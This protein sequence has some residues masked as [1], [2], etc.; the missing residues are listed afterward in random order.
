MNPE[1]DALNA[2]R[3]EVAALRRSLEILQARVDALEPEPKPEPVA[4]PPKPVESPRPAPPPHAFPSPVFSH[5]AVRKS[6]VKP[7]PIPVTPPEPSAIS[8]LIVRAKA[9]V[10]PAPGQSMESYVGTRVVPIIAVLAIGTGVVFLAVLAVQLFSNAWW[11]P[12]ARLAVG[13]AIAAGLLAGGVR[14]RKVSASYG[15]LLFGSGMALTYFITFATYFLPFA[16]VF[17]RPEP[18]LFMLAGVVVAWGVV[19]HFRDSRRT[20]LSMTLLGHFTVALS[21]AYTVPPSSLGVLGIVALSLGSA[22]FMARKGWFLVGFAGML[23]AYGNHLYYLMNSPVSTSVTAFALVFSVALVYFIIFATAEYL[24]ATWHS[25]ALKYRW[26][27]LFVSLNTAAFLLIASGTFTGFAFA[28]PQLHV[29][30]FGTAAV[31]ILA[32]MAHRARPGGDPL[33]NAYFTKAAIVGTIGLALYFEGATLALSITLEAVALLVSARVG[34]TVVSR[35]LSYCVGL[36]AFLLTTAILFRPEIFYVASTRDLSVA[37]PVGLTALVFHIAALLY[38]KTDWRAGQLDESKVWPRLRDVAG[39][40]DLV[41]HDDEK[42][43]SA[44]ETIATL[45]A[46][47]GAILAVL[48]GWRCVSWIGAP[49]MLAALALVATGTAVLLRARPLATASTLTAAAVPVFLWAYQFDA[50]HATNARLK[51]AGALLALMALGELHFRSRDRDRVWPVAR[52]VFT[53]LNIVYGLIIGIAG[54]VLLDHCADHGQWGLFAVGFASSAAIYSV[55][56]KSLAFRVPI[57]LW[58]MM[59]AYGYGGINETTYFLMIV[60]LLGTALL[61]EPRWF[62]DGAWMGKFRDRG[63]PYVS[64]LVPAWLFANY[65]SAFAPEHRMIVLGLGA[66][67]AFVGVVVLHPKAVAWAGALLL[68]LATAIWPDRAPSNYSFTYLVTPLFLVAIALAGDFWLMRRRVFTWPYVNL[69]I[70]FAGIV[71]ALR[72]TYDI[73]GADAAHPWRG[74]V[75]AVFLGYAALSRSFPAG[76]IG[77]FFLYASAAM[78]VIDSFERNLP[79][80]TLVLGYGL[81]ITLFFAVERAFS[82]KL[83]R[84]PNDGKPLEFHAILAGIPVALAVLLMA[85]LPTLSSYYLTI[86]WSV[87]AICTF[88]VAAATREA[89]YRYAALCV[90]G[91]AVLRVTFV[92]VRQLEGVYRIM[93]WIVLGM[94]L[95]GVA[96]AYNVSRGKSKNEKTASPGGD[97]E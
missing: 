39:Q 6:P 52:D 14:M 24:R 34:G 44:K 92:D 38:Y 26:R 61:S 58:T 4:P 10:G 50:P 69:L 59:A 16:R 97:A 18:T 74:I 87:V 60:I 20:A 89:N 73:A 77:G 51:S 17:S 94:V 93:A 29:L 21:T 66:V 23:C 62:G 15:G 75:I 84:T 64:Y 49:Y 35:V 7:P 70:L 5:E 40:L 3:D 79:V 90:L 48:A 13:Y 78:L 96:T 22:W 31:M 25:P 9:A 12:H 86:S 67:A 80:S 11:M 45:Y 81:H 37:V 28:R 95:L 65:S 56:T 63:A 19:A 91:L 85:E 82:L 1:D 30:Y 47:A 41:R 33:F 57:I 8:R 27:T 46:F 43:G 71:L 42:I 36:L 83:E 76:A 72:Y 53:T 32:G 88:G 2:L 54:C 68:V 55:A